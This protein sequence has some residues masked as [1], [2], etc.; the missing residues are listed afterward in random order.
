V[1]E[2][3]REITAAQKSKQEADAPK[4]EKPAPGKSKTDTSTTHKQPPRGGRAKSR[5]S[6]ER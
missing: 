4:A 3:L 6:K 1:K 5:K 2:A